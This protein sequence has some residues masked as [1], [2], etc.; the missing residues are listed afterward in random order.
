MHTTVSDVERVAI[1]SHFLSAQIQLRTVLII[2]FFLN[3]IYFL[4]AITGWF[5]LFPSKA[6]SKRPVQSKHLNFLLSP[7]LPHPPPRYVRERASPVCFSIPL[8]PAAVATIWLFAKDAQREES[9]GYKGA[10][11]WTCE[12]EESTTPSRAPQ[13]RGSELPFDSLTLVPSLPV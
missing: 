2:F 7:P 12:V 1:L 9:G 8:Q 5:T 3:R 10:L 13:M 6:V 11:L 4:L